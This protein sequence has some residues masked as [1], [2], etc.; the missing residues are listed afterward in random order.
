MVSGV[1]RIIRIVLADDHP[2]VLNGLRN[3][4][5]AERD[6]DLVGEASSGLAALK[7]IRDKQPDV[8]VL[9]I[10][11]PELNG[12]VLSRRL[13][14]EMPA[15]RI[16][17]LTLHEDRAYLN[18]ALEAGVQGYI[19][20]RSAAENLVQAIR[21]VVVGGLYIDPGIVGR[22]FASRRHST[23]QTA[24]K[25]VSPALTE[26]ETEVLRMAAL[27]FTNK[28]IALRLDV[29][30]KSVETYKA[31]GLEKL[32]LKTRAELVRYAS[33]QGWLDL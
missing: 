29:G 8:A 25:G 19:L 17:V 4:V 31:R 33:G 7:V 12:I 14:A 21:A 9:D 2:I 30:V 16:L 27:G 15:L 24:S 28:E 20:K 18:Q 5:R 22:V 11:M 3:L 1:T 23:R 32:G 10:S 6:F 13:A 26:R